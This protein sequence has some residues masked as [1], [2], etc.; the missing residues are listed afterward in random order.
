MPI[1]RVELL[2]YILIAASA[3][4]IYALRRIFSVERKVLAIERIILQMDK[5]ITDSLKKKKR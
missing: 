5:K 1:N 4:I 3:G 2:L